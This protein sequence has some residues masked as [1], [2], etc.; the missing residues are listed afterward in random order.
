MPETTI[1]WCQQFRAR[2]A[3]SSSNDGGLNFDY[4]SSWE[5]QDGNNDEYKTEIPAGA[6]TAGIYYYSAWFSL[7]GGVT[8]TKGGI[9]NIWNGGSHPSGVLV[10]RPNAS[11]LAANSNAPTSF[12][13]SGAA[14]GPDASHFTKTGS[15]NALVLTYLGRSGTAYGPSGTAPTNAGSYT[16]NAFLPFDESAADAYASLD[17]AITKKTPTVTVTPGTYTYNGSIQG[18]GVG[19]VNAGGSP[20]AVTLSYEGTA[21]S[22]VSYP[23][24]ATPP[25]EAGTYSLTATVAGDDN[26]EAASSTATAFTIRIA[27]TLPTSISLT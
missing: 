27:R 14:Q 9:G 5:K 7:D 13:Y 1:L 25:T 17:F 15:T 11:T 26:H 20:G 2:L 6:L 12:T 10:V 23:T 24:S 22:G 4:P 21:N 18:P 19:E 8:W 3:L 16:L